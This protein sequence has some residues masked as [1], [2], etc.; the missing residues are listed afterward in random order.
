MSSI[1][2]ANDTECVVISDEDGDDL[3]IPTKISARSTSSDDFVYRGASEKGSSFMGIRS[4]ISSIGE[5]DG[6]RMSRRRKPRPDGIDYVKE[7]EVVKVAGEPTSDGG[8][9]NS[10]KKVGENRTETRSRKRERSG[11]PPS[12]EVK[13]N[14]PIPFKEILTGLEGAAF[15]SRYVF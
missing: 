2:L 13:E 9:I 11:S 4:Y 8:S 15:Q 3:A 5:S 6:R 1:N 14:D 10:D 7:Q 12:V